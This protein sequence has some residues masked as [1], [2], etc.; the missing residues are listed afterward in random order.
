MFKIT[1]TAEDR[2]EIEISGSIDADDMRSG[3]DTL[4]AQSEGI[5][6]GRMLYRIS[7]FKM[8]TLGALGVEFARLPKLFGLIGKFDRC[9]LL[10]DTAWIRT[11]AE[12]EGA[13][14]PG[15]EI[16]SFDFGDVAAA[17]AWLGGGIS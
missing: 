9:A 5:S 4:I 10:C 16:K 12:I 17:E 6:H 14:I 1:R 13:L 3:M 15:L 8:P 2:I 7:D 11:T